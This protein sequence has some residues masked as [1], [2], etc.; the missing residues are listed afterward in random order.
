MSK[1]VGS[2]DDLKL[3]RTF[4]VLVQES[5]VSRA[6]AKLNLSQ[7]TLSHALRQLR[8]LFDDP[9]LV[10]TGGQMSP[11]ARCSELAGEVRELLAR[12]DQLTSQAKLFDPAS[13]RL[14]M[15][16][17]A[18]EF[19][20]DVLAPS[21][22]DEVKKRSPSTEIEFITTD[23]IEA[24]ALLEQG[25]IDFR[26]GWWPQPAPALRRKL[27][28]TDSLCCILRKDH[29]LL[30]GT[31]TKEAY[32]NAVHVRVRRPG[33][34]YSMASIDSAA[35]QLGERLQVGAWVQNAHTLAN[36]VAETD[37][38]GT[39]SKR[40]AKGLARHGIVQRDLPLDVP[41]LK[42]ALYWHERT[43]Q[44]AAH[45]WLRTLLFEVA[46]RLVK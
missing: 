5:S 14:R 4:L 16:I 26:L 32:F 46:S 10:R 13:A 35:S 6:A 27:L 38:V 8:H 31:L 9:L 43:H 28:W 20:T 44:S 21:F 18:P 11:T 34:S 36:V 15:T 39:L 33:R 3:M 2:I 23:P 12:F 24:L 17:M 25:S 42:V 19:A 41:K 30:A 1:S 29:P 37:L 7:P 22:I 45:R 40:L